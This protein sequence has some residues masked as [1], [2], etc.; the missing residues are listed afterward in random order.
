M[1]HEVVAHWDITPPQS[2]WNVRDIFT[3]IRSY[4]AELRLPNNKHKISK[5]SY[6]LVVAHWDS[7]P[8]T[9]KWLD[10][11]RSSS[12][13]ASK[14]QAVLP[15]WNTSMRH[16]IS[17][18][19]YEL[20]VVHWDWYSAL[21][22]WFDCE[23]DIFTASDHT[24]CRIDKKSVA[25]WWSCWT[26]NNYFGCIAEVEAAGRSPIIVRR[27]NRRWSWGQSVASRRLELL[28]HRR[29]LYKGGGIGFGINKLVAW[30]GGASPIISVAWRR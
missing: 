14:R 18:I 29:F 10:C 24:A 8:A 15:I 7:Y 13:P 17:E 11:K 1:C 20:V 19:G 21:Q 9:S 25:W 22:K 26:I 23:R 5:I 2:G 27:W 3:A 6:E 30:R 28:E 16:K 4:R 12:P